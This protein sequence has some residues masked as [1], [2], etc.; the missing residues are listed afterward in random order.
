[1]RLRRGEGI[2]GWPTAPKPSAML[3]GDAACAEHHPQT[4]RGTGQ[5][6]AKLQGLMAP[7]A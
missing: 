5:R 4:F 6:V 1:M 3:E 2:T 7:A